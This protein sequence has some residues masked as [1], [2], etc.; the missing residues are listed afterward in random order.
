MTSKTT[1]LLL[2]A[3]A[4]LGGGC[5]EPR[6]NASLPQPDP[7][8]WNDWH[9]A[10]SPDGKLIAFNSQRDG[11]Y[12]IYLMNADGSEQ[13]RL[14]VNPASDRRPTWLADRSKILFNSDR[15]GNHNI[16]M[17]NPDGTDQ[18]RLTEHPA[19]DR[20]AAW[21]PDGALIAFDTDRDGNTEIYVMNADGSDPVRLTYN[22]QTDQAPRWSPDGKQIAYF[23]QRDGD[24]EIYV[25]D[26][27]G[28]NQ[29]RLTA[30]RGWDFM[31]FWSPDASKIAFDSRRDGRRG[32]CV[33][34]SDGSVLVKLTNTV[35][36]EFVTFVR[37]EGI[38][39][40]KQRHGQ[41]KAV[42]KGGSL[43]LEPEMSALAYEQ[44][45]SGSLEKALDLFRL[46]LDAFPS[47]SSAYA[48]LWRAAT[49]AGQEMPPAEAAILDVFKDEGV[50]AGIE[51][52][53]E[54]KVLF[55]DWLI[56]TE[57]GVNS[58]GY[59]F[60]NSGKIDEA[61]EV[62]EFNVARH[63]QSSNVYDSLGEAYMK[64]GNQALAFKNYQKSLEL[65]PNN[66][67]AV[68]MLKKIGT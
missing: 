17:M 60:L 11:D 44:M 59:Q 7:F 54:A 22:A 58:L 68:A 42:G 10:W 15:D 8:D 20:R 13:T 49:Q 66:T 39:E 55:P 9:P 14:T 27:D 64:A 3:L 47:S 24:P 21:S 37:D 63:P 35:L 30:S 46:N 34:N 12:E 48:D 51:A 43:F 23:S 31:P 40:A 2:T 28:S 56:V 19:D 4:V 53:R 29:R 32:I 67:N 36:S 16:Y 41:A 26:T 18:T 52:Y 61:I 6:E 1:F 50:S 25:M 65:N 5:V 57:G 38:E 45:D 33:M 62:F